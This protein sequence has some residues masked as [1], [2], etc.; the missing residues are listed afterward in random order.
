MERLNQS[1]ALERYVL[2]IL[3]FIFILSENPIYIL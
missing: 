1:M 3:K 2:N